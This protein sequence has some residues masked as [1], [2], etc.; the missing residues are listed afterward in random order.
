M[1]QNLLSDLEAEKKSFMWDLYAERE[2]EN[3]GET[4]LVCFAPRPQPKKDARESRAATG[5]R[6]LQSLFF[7]FF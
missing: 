5:R 1:K 6:G 7:F 2:E 3:E 4:S